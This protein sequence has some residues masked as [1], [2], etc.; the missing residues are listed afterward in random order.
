MRHALVFVLLL[1]GASALLLA[2][3]GLARNGETPPVLALC[4][5]GAAALLTGFGLSLLAG[6][7]RASRLLP[8]TPV[9]LTPIP[10]MPIA[11]TAGPLGIATLA[12]R[13]GAPS[14]IDHD[15]TLEIVADQDGT[16][17]LKL[18]TGAPAGRLVCRTDAGY[19]NTLSQSGREAAIKLAGP[20]PSPLRLEL[21]DG[22]SAT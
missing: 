22:D 20:V 2:L 11:A 7:K 19:F 15:D 12:F 13:G 18:K 4:A 10:A 17:R 16:I 3:D 14:V 21:W 6:P 5:G 8:A 1:G 9:P